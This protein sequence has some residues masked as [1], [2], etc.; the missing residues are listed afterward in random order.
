MKKLVCPNCGKETIPFWK[1]LFELG[2]RMPSAKCK[3]CGK[4]YGYSK[5][6]YLTFGLAFVLALVWVGYSIP[7]F[8]KWV[9]VFGA[10]VPFIVEGLLCFFFVPLVSKEDT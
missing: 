8:S 6:E 9:V 7:R 3:A 1:K 2:P 4:K 10:I 5:I